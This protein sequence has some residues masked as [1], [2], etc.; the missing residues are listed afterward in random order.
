[1]DKEGDGRKSFALLAIAVE[2]IRQILTGN[3]R[4]DEGPDC[5]D[6]VTPAFA[7]EVAGLEQRQRTYTESR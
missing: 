2:Q 4:S 1:V 7:R 3:H 6:E 5:G